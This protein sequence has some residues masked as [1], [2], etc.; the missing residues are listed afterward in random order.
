MKLYRVVI[1]VLISTYSA[2]GLA[3]PTARITIRV[4][5]ET[6]LPVAGANAGLVLEAPKK[7]GEGW[8]TDTSWVPGLTDAEGLFSGEGETASY[9]SLSAK[10]DGYYDV[11]SHF[12]D[13]TGVSGFLGFRKYEPWNPTVE[14]ILKK[15]VNPV[16]MYAVN[17]FGTKSED[18]PQLPLLGRFVGFDIMANDW[19][20]PY[21]LGT[22]ADFLFKVDVERAISNTDHDVTL[23]LQFSNKGDG[24]I[25]YTPDIRKGKSGL[26]LPYHAP[27][28]GYE[29][30][31]N[32]KYDNVPGVLKYSAG[33][34]PEYDTNYFFRVRTQLDKE[35]LV[36][37]GL[38]GKI[39]GDISL[40]NYAWLHTQ[41]P[42]VV[43]D[44]YL[45]PNINDTN[46]EFD[47]DKN[48]FKN[49]PEL[50]QVKNP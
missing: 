32:K 46:I 31:F 6:G 8:G 36:T 40:G 19:I 39:H 5:D 25:E 24:L 17:M 20:V 50:Q 13:F 34:N 4:V 29:A 48:L 33:G 1:L 18:Y 12:N 9:V 7:K 3:L 41:K 38:Y 30:E 2:V 15:K 47:P 49:L 44:Y 43:F 37:G 23:T 14:M 45:N 28:S 11:S 35:G 22:H 26:R 10:K 21:G 16:A 42:Y 27:T